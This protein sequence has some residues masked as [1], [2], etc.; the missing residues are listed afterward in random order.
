MTWAEI[1]IKRLPYIRMGERLFRGMYHSVT[2]PYLESLKNLTTP[3]QIIEASRSAQISKEEVQL[4]Y[5][6]FYTKTGVGFAKS[7]RAKHRKFAME[8]KADEDEWLRIITEYVRAKTANKITKAIST[9]Y[10]DIERIA[11]AAVEEGIRE[12]YGMEKIARIIR[13]QQ[14]DIELWKAL[15]IARTEVVAASSEG[16]KVGA[17]SLPGNKVKVW[18]STFDDRS[19]PE[20][21]AMDGKRVAFNEMFEVDGD[22]MEYPGDPS[23]SAGNIVNCRCGY[24]II[25]ESDKY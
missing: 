11:R 12:G 25:V 6:R 3:E 15:R 17:E 21:M 19:R 20:H 13:K 8:T 16:I 7:F 9:H 23:A 2:A 5:E 14:G 4:A 24:E 18:I 10:E 1:N 22:M